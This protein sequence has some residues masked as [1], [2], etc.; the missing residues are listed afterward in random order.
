MRTGNLRAIISNG[1]Y[2][3]GINPWDPEDSPE[4][5]TGNKIT[6]KDSYKLVPVLYASWMMRAKAMADLPFTIYGKGD[7]EVDNSDDYENKVGFLPDPYTFMWRAEAAIAGYGS[8]YYFIE[9]NRARPLALRYWSPDSII[10][11]Y[12]TSLYTDL[13]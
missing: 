5:W 9:R 13:F 2:F 6:S 8:F 11:I 1:R 10:N 7:T 12:V 3:K 4:A